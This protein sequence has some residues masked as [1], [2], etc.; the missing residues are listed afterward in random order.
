M[1]CINVLKFDVVCLCKNNSNVYLTDTENLKVTYQS[2]YLMLDRYLEQY[3]FEY[4]IVVY[5]Y[6]FNQNTS[7]I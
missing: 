3:F 4:F 2:I 7:K 1:S 5:L 6:Y